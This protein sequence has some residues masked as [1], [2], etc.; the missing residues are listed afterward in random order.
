MKFLAVL[1]LLLVPLSLC[2]QEKER[3]RTCRIIYLMRGEDGPTEAYLF[4]GHQAHKVL[5]PT[6][7]FSEVIELP[8]GNIT[9]GMSAD[10]VSSAEEF[11]A[12][13]PTIAIPAQVNDVYL[14]LHNDPKNKVFPMSMKSINVDDRNLKAGQTLWINL[15]QHTVAAQMGEKEIVISPG[16][17]SVSEAP[18][19]ESGYFLA[20]FRYQPESKGPFLPVMKKSWWF[21]A[22]SRN[23]GFIY[24][25]SHGGQLH[26]HSIRDCLP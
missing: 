13:A 15:S 21:D 10:S 20:K 2:A 12:G 3:K 6:L 26:I 11:P 4:D 17:I 16:K 25:A 19:R 1:C 5:L 18:L 14:L 9:V 7:N 8:R 23:L 24:H 22:T